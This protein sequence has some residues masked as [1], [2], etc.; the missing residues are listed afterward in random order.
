MEN[1]L[2]LGVPILKHIRVILYANA[3]GFK[4]RLKHHQI[5]LDIFGRYGE[6]L[7]ITASTF[8]FKRFFLCAETAHLFWILPV[9]L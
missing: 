5:W 1:L 8:M 7:N 2:F 9:F 4:R 3:A 6:T